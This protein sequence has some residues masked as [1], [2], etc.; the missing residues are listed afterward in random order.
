MPIEARLADLP[1]GQ[2]RAA[3]AV[4]ATLRRYK[5][6]IIEAVSIGILVKHDGSLIEL[7]PKTK[8]LDLSFISPE[9]IDSPR[10]ARIAK[11]SSGRA[12]F[13]HLTDKS[14]VDAELRGWLANAIR[15]ASARRPRAAKRGT[16]R[17]D[18]PRARARRTGPRE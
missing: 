3:L 17:S 15:A 10:I 11:W 5:Q 14:D 18:T 12:Y 13:V 8:W 2:R 9:T 6:L 7:R 1:D 16:A 4:L